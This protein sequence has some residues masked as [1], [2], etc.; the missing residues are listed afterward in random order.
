MRLIGLVFALTLGLAIPPNIARAQQP[1]KVYRI[2]YLSFAPARTPIDDSFEQALNKLGYVEGHNLIVERRYTAGQP[3]QLAPAAGELVRLNVDLIVVWS[4]AAT[5]A[6]KNATTTIPVVFLA[7]GAA[8]EQ[9]LVSGL[10]RP[11]GNLTGITFQANRTL[12]PK[13]FEYLKELLPKLSHVVVLRSPAEDP[14][15]ETGNYQT[16]ARAFGIRL[17]Q[18]ALHKPEDLKDAFTS[19]E[20][21]RPQALLCAP[22]GLLS[23]SDGR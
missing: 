14:A 12:A 16:A 19:I 6:V 22:S 10:A 3:D 23:S 18:I 8:V 9:G 17:Q 1:G 5:V 2:G 7:G 4:P 20:K 13:Y 11:K 15:D 21:N